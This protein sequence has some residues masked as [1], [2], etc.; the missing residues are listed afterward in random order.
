MG[1]IYV[2]FQASSV[3]SLSLCLKYKFSWRTILFSLRIGFWLP[4]SVFLLSASESSQSDPF[5]P[6]WTQYLCIRNDNPVVQTVASGSTRQRKMNRAVVLEQLLGK[7]EH[8]TRLTGFVVS[9]FYS[10]FVVK[11]C[12]YWCLSRRAALYQL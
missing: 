8:R 2:N 4:T 5:N 3:P 1:N 6:T 9:I 11:R 10:A 7:L 12:V